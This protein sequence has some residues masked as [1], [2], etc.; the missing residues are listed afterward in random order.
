MRWLV[1]AAVTLATVSPAPD[2]SGPPELVWV[3]GHSIPA[4]VGASAGHSWPER[5]AQLDDAT[6]LVF[7]VGGSVLND[8]AGSDRTIETQVRKALAE[9]QGGMPDRVLID[10]GTNDLVTHDS[11]DLVVSMWAA[12]NVDMMLRSHGVAPEWMPIL[13]MGY[14]TSHP[15]AWLPNLNSRRDTW[16]NWLGAMAD[17][18]AFRVTKGTLGA[19]PV[20]TWL[21]PDGLHPSNAGALLVADAVSK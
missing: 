11:T 4:G 5:L 12:I 10:A 15:D 21:M 3:F 9:Q 18:G 14:G 16:N 1:V 13:P 19:F 20:P 2:N 17:A 7:A 8:P 6:V